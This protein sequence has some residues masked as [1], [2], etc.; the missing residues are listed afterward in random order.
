MIL[1]C[2]DGLNS[3]YAAELKLHMPYEAT[4]QIEPELC[5]QFGSKLIPHTMHVWPSMFAGRIVRHPYV[6]REQ[7]VDPNR[8][9][10]RK[11]L[12]RLGVRW[13]RRGVQ[14]K[15]F[16]ETCDTGFK[17]IIYEKSIDLED[18]VFGNY[19]SFLYQVPGLVDNFMLGGPDE[20]YHYEHQVWGVLAG[21]ADKLP[22]DLVA[23]YTRQPDHLGHK[24]RNPSVVYREPFTIAKRLKSDVMVLSDH[25]CDYHTGDHTMKGYIGSSFPFKA[26][27]MLDV[28][29]IIEARMDEQSRN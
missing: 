23:L 22:Y 21:L 20:W 27:S 16:N 6:D 4:P 24:L 17:P 2:M 14:V 5:I 29:K 1:L 8:M 25:G 3:R 15:G 19:H 28:R 11:I 10:F 18:T 7:N 9:R 13:R 12:H 26:E